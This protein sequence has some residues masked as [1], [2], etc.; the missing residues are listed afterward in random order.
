[1]YKKRTVGVSAIDHDDV[2]ATTECVSQLRYR[3]ATI[4]QHEREAIAVGQVEQALGTLRVW[5][6][7]VAGR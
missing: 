3:L 2:A 7:E 4:A 5:P 6:G 1:M